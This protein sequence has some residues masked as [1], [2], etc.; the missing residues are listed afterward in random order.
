MIKDRY[1]IQLGKFV[2]IGIVA[3]LFHCFTARW[4]WVQI[5]QWGVVF[6]FFKVVF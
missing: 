4:S 3:P 2:V 1:F 5:H 6:F